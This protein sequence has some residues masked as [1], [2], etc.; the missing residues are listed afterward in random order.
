VEYWS[1]VTDWQSIVDKHGGLVWSIAY[2]LLGNDAD[3]AD[4]FQETFVS[5]FEFS[6]KQRIRSYPAL[7]SRLATV[8]AIDQLRSRNRPSNL[9]DCRD[10]VDNNPSP[11]QHLAAY[12]LAEQL[13]LA[14]GKLPPG[15]AEVFC[16]RCLNGLSY[17]AIARQLGIKRNAVGV[18]LHRARQKLRG[19]LKSVVVSDEREVLP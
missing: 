4:C 19:L 2:R 8:R 18:M 10:V 16:L 15:E 13:R 17:R 11:Q 12:E 3:A 1:K 14:L 5:A 6:R 7:L 9:S